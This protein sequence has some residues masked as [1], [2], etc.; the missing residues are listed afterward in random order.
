MNEPLNEKQLC[1]DPNCKQSIDRDSAAHPI[2]R[3]IDRL[4]DSDDGNNP[5]AFVV[6]PFGQKSV[7]DGRL[8]DFDIVYDR[9]IKPALIEGG[10]KPFRADEETVSGDILTDMFQELLL[11]DL[12]VADMSIDNANVFYELGVRHAFRKRGVVHIQS[13]RDYMP[14]DVFN[15]RTMPYHVDEQ[16]VPDAKHVDRD[17]KNLVRI[18]CETWASDVEAV[19]SPILVY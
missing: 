1:V 8:I 3:M 2:N 5:H 16:G 10:F 9:L 14:F 4:Q 17:R 11:A 15:V 13:S 7:P 18:M 12:V 6:M 19:H